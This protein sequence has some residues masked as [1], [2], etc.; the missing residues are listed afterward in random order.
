LKNAGTKKRLQIKRLTKPRASLAVLGV[1]AP[2]TCAIKPAESAGSSREIVLVAGGDVCFD[3]HLRATPPVVHYGYR[4]GFSKKRDF[5]ALQRY[6]DLP[7]LNLVKDHGWRDFTDE[8]DD[9]SIPVEIP[10][11]DDEDLRDYPFEYLHDVFSAADVT[12]INLETP[13]GDRLEMS[14]MFLSRSLFARGLKN[15]GVKVVSLA[16]N[17]AFDAGTAGIHSTLENLK[18]EGIQACGAGLSLTE[19]TE[20]VITSVDGLKIAWVGCTQKCNIGFRQSSAMPG[21]SGILPMDP[22]IVAD[23]IAKARESSHIMVV[24]PHWSIEESI[25]NPEPLVVECARFFIDAGADIVLGSGPHVVQPIE[26]YRGKPIVYCMGNL[27]FGHGQRNWHDNII[28]QIV[29]KAGC[30]NALKIMPVSGRP[31]ELFQP[32]ILTGERAHQ[33]LEQLKALSVPFGT[34]I[35]T[36]GDIGLIAL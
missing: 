3:P 33:A 20:P 15:A 8:Y 12:F 16:N 7:L 6:A 4:L 27:I 9:Y 28:V 36:K 17:H 31:A 14:G 10:A 19:A 32:K 11:L 13:L 26:I 29:L 34:S 5:S 30:V 35:E 21:R 22:Q 1:K 18:R 25:K 24:A 23:A 2:K